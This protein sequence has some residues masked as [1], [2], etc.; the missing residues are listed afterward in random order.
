MFALLCFKYNCDNNNKA[1]ITLI[2]IHQLPYI[3]N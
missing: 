2:D 3:I 1:F